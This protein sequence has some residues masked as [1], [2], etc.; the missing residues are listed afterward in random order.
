MKGHPI[1]GIEQS[2]GLRGA[3][4]SGILG[5][6]SK[7]WSG[8]HTKHRLMYHIVWI[9]K[10]RKRVLKGALAKRL[11]ELLRECAEVNGWE[12][13]ELNVQVDHVH[14]MVQLKPSVSVSKAVQYF[15]G[16][17]SRVLRAEF[18]DLK[19]HLWGDSLWGDGFFAETV[20]K[21]DEEII[22]AYVR[23]Q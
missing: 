6:M 22:R 10:Y 11:E 20:G 4:V 9:P 3:E 18:P 7:Y 21:V 19:E 2:V 1:R 23:N 15:K 13:R 8:A 5:S 16:G 14:M 17:S 12:I